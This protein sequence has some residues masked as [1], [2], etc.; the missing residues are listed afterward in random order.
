[1]MFVD[2]DKIDETLNK[3]ENE[4]ILICFLYFNL[5]GSKLSGKYIKNSK[6]DINPNLIKTF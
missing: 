2:I 3:I 1:M 5:S 6:E 4:D